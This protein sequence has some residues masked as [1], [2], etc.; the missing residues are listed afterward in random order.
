MKILIGI[1][2]IIPRYQEQ[3]GEREEQQP[4]LLLLSASVSAPTIKGKGGLLWYLIMIYND[5]CE[6]EKYKIFCKNSLLIEKLFIKIYN[7]IYNCDYTQQHY[8]KP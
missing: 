4:Q 3:G 6:T 2:T 7:F 8:R 1:S 5:R